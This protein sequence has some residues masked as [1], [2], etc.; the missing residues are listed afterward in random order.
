MAR[1]VEEK[2]TMPPTNDRRVE[3]NDIAT[4]NRLQKTLNVKPLTPPPLKV[5][6]VGLRNEPEV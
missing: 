6:G 5:V 1:M 2:D 4:S 3:G